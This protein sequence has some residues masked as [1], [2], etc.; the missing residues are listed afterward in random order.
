PS[1]S[2]LI[3]LAQILDCSTDWLLTGNC[4]I[5]DIKDFN[6]QND[7]PEY[8]NLYLQLSKSD[9]EERLDII[10]LKLSRYKK[11]LSFH[12]DNQNNDSQLA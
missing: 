9:Q 2:A 1:A 4:R 10:R 8:Q 11:G 7:T 6:I 3:G 5:C 12:L